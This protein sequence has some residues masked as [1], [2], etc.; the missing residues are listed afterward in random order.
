MESEGCITHRM[1]DARVFSFILA[2]R[3]WCTCSLEAWIV[4]REFLLA[5]TPSGA[6]FAA[7]EACQ[8]NLR[9]HVRAVAF[10]ARPE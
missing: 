4:G 3:L 6:G 2:P 10:R 7:Y 9:R 8:L 5:N 1:D